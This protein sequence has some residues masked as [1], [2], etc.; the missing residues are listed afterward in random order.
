MYIQF[1]DNIYGYENMSDKSLV[2]EGFWDGEKKLLCL[3][4]CPILEMNE[5]AA[6]GFNGDCS[7]GLSLWFPVVFYLRNRSAAL[8]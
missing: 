3:L 6:N 5:Y 7:I 4:A 2:G 8:G 1:S